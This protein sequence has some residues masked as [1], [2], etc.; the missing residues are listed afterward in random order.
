MARADVITSAFQVDHSVDFTS[1]D[2][3]DAHWASTLTFTV[4]PEFI[5]HNG[6]SL[7]FWPGNFGITF[8]SSR[9]VRLD[10]SSLPAG[11]SSDTLNVSATGA[12][13]FQVHEN[14]WAG[15]IGFRETRSPSLSQPSPGGRIYFS[16]LLLQGTQ[17]SCPP[18]FRGRQTYT[19]AVTGHRPV[20]EMYRERITY[21][22]LIS[23]VDP[24]GELHV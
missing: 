22:F 13:T 1:A 11:T 12:G 4:A 17:S 15:H 21:C 6:F 2:F 5:R 19:S 16:R 7:L 18:V 3:S 10:Q 8:S 20:T 9:N 23:F 14:C 24:N